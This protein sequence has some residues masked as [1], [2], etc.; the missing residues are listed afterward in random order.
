MAKKRAVYHS[1]HL[2]QFAH[3][4]DFLFDDFQEEGCQAVQDGH[5][6][7]VAA[8]TGAGKTIVGEFAAY[9]ALQLGKKAFYTTPIKAL[10][11][12]KY[13]EFC[14][15]YGSE[16]VGLLTGD[17]SINSHAPIVVMTTEVLRNMLYSGSSNLDN[18]GFVVMD[19]V[20]Y[21]ADRFRGP[22][23]EE[24]IIHLAADVQVVALSA[25]V[26]NAEEFGQWL[27]EVRGSTKVIVSE[28]RPVPLTQHMMVGKKLYSLYDEGTTN[29]NSSLNRALKHAKSQAQAEK[30]RKKANSTRRG[31][32]RHSPAARIKPPSRIAVIDTLAR[33]NM[34]PAIVFIFS[35]AGCENA[36]AAALA[37]GVDL[38]T[39]EEAAQIRNIVEQRTATVPAEDLQMLGYH[40]WVAALERGVAAHHAGLLPVFKETVEELFSAGLVKL[41]YATET[42]ALGINM[43]ARTVVLETLSKWNGQ[44]HVDLTPGEYTQLTGRAGRRG[45][46]TQGHAV[47]LA[48]GD[49]DAYS[50]SQLAS[51]RTYPLRS[52]FRPTYNMAVN[53]LSHTTRSQAR[54]ILESSFAQFQADR[55]V[56]EL[57]AA[58]RRLRSQMDS[59][60]DS[61]QCHLGDFREYQYLRTKISEAEKSLAH[62]RSREKRQANS[63]SMEALRSGDVVIFPSGRRLRHGVVL[64]ILHDRQGIAIPELLT[65]DARV[66]QLAPEQAPG[67]VNLVGHLAGTTRANLGSHR[68][69]EDLVRKLRRHLRDGTLEDTARRQRTRRRTDASDDRLAS[70]VEQLRHNIATWRNELAQHPCHGCPDR[71]EH[72]RQ[73]RSWAKKNAERERL[74]ARIDSRTGNVA[75]TFDAVCDVL[76]HLGY[77]DYTDSAHNRDHVTVT[78]AGRML[79]RI[80]AERDLLIAHSI[81]QGVFDDL[82][83]ADLAAAV[84][85]CVYEPRAG[86]AHAPLKARNSALGQALA[87]IHR[88]A[89]TIRDQES[90]ARLEH[91]GLDEPSLS[92]AMSLWAQGADMSDVL[93]LS[94]M[95]PGDFVRWSK[96]VLD[97]L[98]QLADLRSNDDTTLSTIGARAERAINQMSRGVVAYSSV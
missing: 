13:T 25:T 55:S 37:S 29:I 78:D 59:M 71:E 12:Q 92:P 6:V 7:L 63:R 39:Q 94:E 82:M 10:S 60:E 31:M 24:V 95:T 11:N 17:S 4:C 20:H 33:H 9:L 38:T 93:N 30:A 85:S 32:P 84:C 42:L 43:P 22:V 61:M 16:N 19:E 52:A 68:V 66:I 27:S 23:W 57:A 41:V 28:H 44:G 76:Q 83:P 47:V 49:I 58:T 74:Y 54:E 14:K 50:V 72:A 45:I 67:G 98:R 8:P 73:G 48:Q 18:L 46:D 79:A 81:R 1:S 87:R 90:L 5:S 88:V 69:R 40:S 77:I 2:A 35:R 91:S 51:K 21:L 36:L 97:V 86:A 3:R 65:E 80:Y 89:V 62:T 56:V 64:R 15:S 53:L 34:L 96:M 70:E 75:R 26:S